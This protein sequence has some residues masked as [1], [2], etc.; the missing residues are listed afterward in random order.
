MNPSTMARALGRRGG[1]AR[2]ARLSDA[3]TKRI[4]RLGADARI[5]SIEAARRIAAN[6]D[7]AAMVEALRPPLP[8]RRLNACDGPL[9]SVHQRPGS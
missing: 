3:E 5:R 7:Y 6:F 4:A 9:P 2:A 8:T 1:L